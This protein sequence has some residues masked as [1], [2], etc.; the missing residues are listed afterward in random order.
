MA[1][2]RGFSGIPLK[3]FSEEIKK[4]AN[5]FECED[6]QLI[7]IIPEMSVELNKC[8]TLLND[9]LQLDKTYVEYVLNDLE[10]IDKQRKEHI[11]NR[12][13]SERLFNQL[14]HRIQ[15][16]VNDLEAKQKDLLS[17]LVKPGKTTFDESEHFNSNRH[18]V[19]T[20]IEYNSALDSKKML[21]QIEKELKNCEL[22]SARINRMLSSSKKQKEERYRHADAMLKRLGHLSG[23]IAEFHQSKKVKQSD[24]DV[25]E[26][27]YTQLKE[28]VIY[29]QCSEN[30]E[31]IF[32]DIELPRV[33]ISTSSQIQ[34]SSLPTETFSPAGWFEFSR[35]VSKLKKIVN[36]ENK[37]SICFH[38]LANML[39][40]DWTEFYYEL[41]FYPKRGQEII[42]KDIDQI[43]FKHDRGDTHKV[44]NLLISLMKF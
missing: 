39:G 24:L 9:W 12:H 29:K 7:L 4:L 16:L 30:L 23:V 18:N 31:K 3:E 43:L 1:K 10:Q 13:F 27:A 6:L 20:L 38:V 25:L 8:I 44:E 33:K 14:N 36:L 42:K 41:P 11:A 32:Y 22:E 26:F 19:V 21:D 28:I 37:F 2:K 17:M 40:A 5:R 15:L 34:Y 35:I